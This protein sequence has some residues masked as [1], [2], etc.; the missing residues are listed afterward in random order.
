[1]PLCWFQRGGV[2]LAATGSPKMVVSMLDGS[3]LPSGH[4]C[5]R[6]VPALGTTLSDDIEYREFDG[7]FALEHREVK[8]KIKAGMYGGGKP[9]FHHV[10]VRPGEGFLHSD[11]KHDRPQFLWKQQIVDHHHFRSLDIE[12]ERTA[13]HHPANRSLINWT[14]DHGWHLA[15]DFLP[16]IGTRNAGEWQFLWMSDLHVGEEKFSEYLG[17][18]MRVKI[19][20]EVSG[21]LRK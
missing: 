11:S 4:L 14:K 15:L 10:Y 2:A 6:V 8:G 1:L 5:L 18:N 13:L 21:L 16:T 20:P 9:G 7:K 12:W 17:K 3:E 19:N